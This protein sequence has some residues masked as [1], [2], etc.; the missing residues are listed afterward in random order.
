[1]IV[2]AFAASLFALLLVSSHASA[3]TLPDSIAGIAFLIGDWHGDGTSEGG[4]TNQGTSSIHLI[5]G[6]NALLRRDHTDVTDKTGKLQ[7]SF[8]QVMLIYPEGGTLHADYLDGA[9]VIHYAKATVSPGV[10]VMFESA[11]GTGA[12]VFHLTYTKTDAD[13]LGIAF[14]M[15]PPGAPKFVTVASGSVHRDK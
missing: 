9:H 14:E 11:S 2:R 6:G 15:Q 3:Q 8:D 5:V 13:T 1:M 10:S 7:E 4:M 12:P